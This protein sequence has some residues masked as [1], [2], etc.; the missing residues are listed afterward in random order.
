MEAIDDLI[1]KAL[2]TRHE[3]SF[4]FLLDEEFTNFVQKAA[5][6]FTFS[7]YYLQLL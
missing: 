2:A 5:M 3:R 7:S 6:Y 4:L 1:L